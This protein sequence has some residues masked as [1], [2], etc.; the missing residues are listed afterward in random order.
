[1]QNFP[2]ILFYLKWANFQHIKQRLEQRYQLNSDIENTLSLI[3]LFL[4]LIFFCHVF[5]ALWLWIARKEEENN[6]QSWTEKY[7]S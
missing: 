5:A 6:I 2:L 4:T 3:K 7:V 1:V